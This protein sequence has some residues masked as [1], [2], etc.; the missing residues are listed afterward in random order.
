M[1]AG[2]L[3]RWAWPLVS[4]PLLVLTVL[5]AHALVYAFGPAQRAS[6][7]WVTTGALVATLLWLGFTLAFSV[8]INRFAAPTHTYGALAGI[9]VLML[10]LYGTAVVLLLGA[11]VDRLLAPAAAPGRAPE[12]APSR[13]GDAGPR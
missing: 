4:W 9:A 5:G 8:Y 10:Y 1:A 6:R 3:W 7:R 2:G 11:V 12:P 13:D